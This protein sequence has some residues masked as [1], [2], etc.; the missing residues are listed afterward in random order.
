[1]TEPTRDPT[2]ERFEIETS[3]PAKL[4]RIVAAG[5]GGLLCGFALV[6]LNLLGPLVA[7]GGYGATNLVFGALGVL[8]V[9]VATHPTYRAARKLDS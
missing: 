7:G 6:A 9:V 5:T 3:D 4:R 1:M 2:M 8:A